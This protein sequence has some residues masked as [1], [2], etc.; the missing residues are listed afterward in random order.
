MVFSG[1]FWLIYYKLMNQSIVLS[2]V[3]NNFYSNISNSAGPDQRAPTG[4]L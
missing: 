1:P 2:W 3:F 4:A